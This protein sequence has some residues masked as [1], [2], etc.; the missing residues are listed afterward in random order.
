MEKNETENGYISHLEEL[1]MRII[2]SILFFS[3]IFIVGLIFI[4]KV[5]LFLQ[6]PVKNY[7]IKLYYFKPYEKFMAYMKVNAVLSFIVSVPFILYQV[8]TFIKPAL[9]KNEAKFLG[10]IT[11]L[12][13]AVFILGGVF[14]FR[15]ISPA[16]LKFFI[17][18]SAGDNVLPVW[19]FGDYFDMVIGFSIVTGVLFQM[20][21]VIVSAVALEVVTVKKIAAYRKYIVILIAVAAAIFS[22]GPDVVSQL[23]IGVPLYVL[24][25][26]SLITGMILELKR[27]KKQTKE[28]F[29]YKKYYKN[30]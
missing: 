17:E 24:F 30:N 27:K 5:S 1:R 25:E 19:S 14:A 8:W 28:N 6:E 20:P 2:F 13:P 15:L 29:D 16:A 12:I 10:A 26:M 9:K 4:D 7:N 22:P 21:L 23:M 3:L 11:F 18:F